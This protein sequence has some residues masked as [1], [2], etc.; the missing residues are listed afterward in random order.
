MNRGAIMNATWRSGSQV[1]IGTSQRKNLTDTEKTPG[2]G[3]YSINS[4]SKLGKNIV[5]TGGRSDFNKHDSEF[6]GPA[7]YDPK[8]E[9]V[10]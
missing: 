9:V 3:A 5:I 1:K 8:T 6:P 7:T 2:P 4:T 10:K